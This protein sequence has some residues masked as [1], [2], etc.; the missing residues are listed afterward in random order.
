MKKLGLVLSMS[1]LMVM[2][3]VVPALGAGTGPLDH[4]IQADIPFDF[5]VGDK[6]FPAGTYTFADPNITPGVLLIRSLDGHESMLVATRDVENLTRPDETKLV[7]SRY[8]DLYFLA[9][10]WT[11]GDV[12]GLELLKSSTESEVAE[13]FSRQVLALAG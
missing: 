10:V 6:T 9:Q 7:F 8:G 5:M 4:K 11:V 13:N 12:S 3:A 2:L 1:S